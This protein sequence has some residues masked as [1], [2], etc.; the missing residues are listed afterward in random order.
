MNHLIIIIHIDEDI[1][2]NSRDHY[3]MNDGYISD[4]SLLFTKLLNDYDVEL[5][6]SKSISKRKQ[7]VSKLQLTRII[8]TSKVNDSSLLS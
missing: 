2:H 1:N 3:L 5:S 7:F 6:L 4:I 8:I